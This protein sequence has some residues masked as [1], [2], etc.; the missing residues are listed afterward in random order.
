MGSAVTW[1]K[2]NFSRKRT[3]R[4]QRID[5]T[6]KRRTAFKHANGET[7][8][9]SLVIGSQLLNREWTQIHT[10]KKTLEG[11]VTSLTYLNDGGGTPHRNAPI[12]EHPC[13]P[14]STIF[15]FLA[16]YAFSSGQSPYPNRPA[17]S[18]Q[19]ARPRASAASSGLGIF[20]RFS[21]ILI[22]SCTCFLSALP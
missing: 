17:W 14:W 21:R 6:L 8:P 7:E 10:N 18:W 16:L 4:A 20:S 19:M 11:G 3:Q 9:R 5:S 1:G 22:I 12:R 13:N 2:N 15:L